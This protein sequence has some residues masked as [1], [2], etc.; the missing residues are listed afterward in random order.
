MRAGTSDET[1]GE[2]ATGFQELPFSKELT[3]QPSLEVRE[4]PGTGVS[5][6]QVSF[7]VQGTERKKAR[8]SLHICTMQGSKTVMGCSYYAQTHIHILQTRSWGVTTF[9]HHWVVRH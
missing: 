7:F 4:V 3:A 9:Q 5:A 2:G 1:V 8:V 6:C